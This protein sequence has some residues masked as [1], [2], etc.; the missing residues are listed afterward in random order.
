[1]A[2]TD[3][4]WHDGRGGSQSPRA[5]MAGDEFALDRQQLVRQTQ[6]ATIGQLAASLAHELRNPLAV[7]RNTVY[8]IKRKLAKGET[9]QAMEYL[10]L[11]DRE[12]SSADRMIR[13]MVAMT[14]GEPPRR[15]LVELDELLAAA[16]ERLP[17]GL[18][19]DWG[20]EGPGLTLHVDRDQFV[21][22]FGN[23][24][25]NA[26]QAMGGDGGRISVLSRA[27]GE[28]DEI[29]VSDTGPGISPEWAEQVFEPLFTSRRSGAGLGLT[30]CRQIVERHGGTITVEPNA[31]GAV[32]RICLP[33]G[34]LDGS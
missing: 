1:M 10:D 28:A 11:I 5:G 20:R 3:S 29:R 8:L 33:R 4:G 14:R 7:V 6:L 12:L 16:R 2:S 25:L 27:G 19:I 17:S 9:A 31:P 22:V 15:Q 13:E 21:Q 26:A 32:L 34:P 23:L 24:F 30:I 18:R